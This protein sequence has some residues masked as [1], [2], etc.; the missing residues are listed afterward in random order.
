MRSVIAVCLACGGG[1][2]F[3][4]SAFAET[5]QHSLV[6]GIGTDYDT[7]P[8]M[9]SGS[10][11]GVMRYR[12]T[13]QYT[14]TFTED[15]NELIF[16][17]GALI[18]RSSNQKVSRD[19]NDP[20]V[21]LGWRH[22]L[23]SGEF[24]LDAAASKMSA[25]TAELANNGQVAAD[26]TQTNKSLG[27][28]WQYSLT[29]RLGFALTGDYRSITSDKGNSNSSSLIDYTT[30]STG[31]SVNYNLG[32]NSEIFTSLTASHYE[33]DNA[34]RPSSNTYGGVLGYKRKISDE[35]AWSLQ[36]GP[37]RITGVNPVSSW[38]GGGQVNYTG[39]KVNASLD[40]GRS[41]LAS[42]VTGGF[43]NSEQVKFQLSYPLDENTRAGADY[44]WIKSKTVTESTSKVYGIF[45]SREL[46]PA[47]TVML[48]YQNRQMERSPGWA[49]SANMLGVTFNYT[50]PDF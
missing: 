47:W 41:V 10:H 15:L 3:S 46:S 11:D 6:A 19:R 42:S 14:G 1:G 28:R 5:L 29:E 23:E 32:E 8:R 33:P 2:L 7:N 37:V 49:A 36:G 26:T 27:S 16:S 30:T 18:E 40:V 4:T 43:S 34:A 12:I 24:S 17:A 38:Q 39:E 45:L 31:L 9:A 44:S 21:R 35:F 13:P 20:N 48:R 22:T 25:R 50:L